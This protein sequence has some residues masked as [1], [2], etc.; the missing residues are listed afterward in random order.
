MNVLNVLMISPGFPAEMPFFTRGLARVGAN[1]IGIGDQAQSVL[2]EIARESLSAYFQVPSFTDEEAIFRQVEAIHKKA[3]LDRIECLWE[4]FMILAAKLREH[5]GL[6]GM[7]VEE[8]IPFRDK[9]I[10]KKRLDEAGI[11]TPRHA[12]VTTVDGCRQAAAAIGFPE[13]SIVVKPIAGA[14]AAD[15]YHIRSADELEAVLPALRHVPEV[16]VE[17]FIDGD[18]Y[19]Y[20]TICI[21]GKIEHFS[22]SFYR[23][24]ALQA[25]THEWLSPQT[26]VVRRVEDEALGPGCEMGEAVIKALNFRTGFTHME[27]FRTLS[28]EAVFGEIAARPPGAHLVDLINYASDIDV[29]T[30]WA[31]AICHGRF[32][33][34]VDRRYNAAWIYKRA[35]GEGVIQR[36]EGL[37][38]LMAE[39]GEHVMLLDLLPIGAPRRNW[40]QTLVSDGMIIVRHPDLERTLQIA[41]RFATELR[42]Y[43]G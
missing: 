37:A 11:R 4:P 42:M 16:S 12:S 18:D 36:I 19:T 17:E 29:F 22:I 34:T 26:V 31:E 33:Q 27:W 8:T 39:L 14:G 32:T 7:T 35:E 23:P 5:L 1:A 43:A 9:E 6:P 21:D 3:R 30:G 41:D 28:G 15:T 10:M 40:K 2:P 25:R 24:R 13:R 38:P 20:E